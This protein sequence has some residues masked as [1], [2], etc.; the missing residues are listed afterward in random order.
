MELSKNKFLPQT[1]ETKL[2]MNLF[3]YTVACLFISVVDLSSK[4]SCFS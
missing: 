3:H 2:S 1:K 4:S